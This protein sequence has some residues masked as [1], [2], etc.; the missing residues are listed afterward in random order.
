[1]ANNSIS[2]RTSLS[3]SPSS[4][5]EEEKA[6]RMERLELQFWREFRAI[7]VRRSDPGMETI[8]DAIAQTRFGKDEAQP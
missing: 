3:G 2:I 6:Q 8:V 5:T 7:V 1:M 4:F